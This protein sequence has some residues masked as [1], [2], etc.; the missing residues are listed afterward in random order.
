[1]NKAQLAKAVNAE[2]RKGV[3]PLDAVLNVIGRELLSGNRVAITGFGTFDVVHRNERTARNPQTGEQVAVPEKD[4]PRWRPGQN[5]TDL[6]N[7]KPAPLDM[8]IA[9][10]APKGSRAGG[11]R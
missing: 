1:M 5:L 11:V 4:V 10:K 2:I 6:L 3:P 8:T 9:S 7:G